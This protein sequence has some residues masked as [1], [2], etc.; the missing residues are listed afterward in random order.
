MWVMKVYCRLLVA[1]YLHAL[2]LGFCLLVDDTFRFLS[3]GKEGK[4]VLY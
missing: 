3:R 1:I 4:A 2:A